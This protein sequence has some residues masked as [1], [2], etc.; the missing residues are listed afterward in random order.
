MKTNYT[1]SLVSALSEKEFE[2]YC[3]AWKARRA[4]QKYEN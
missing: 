4:R 3:Q 1:P 2:S